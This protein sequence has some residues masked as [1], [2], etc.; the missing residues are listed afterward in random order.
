[1]GDS[2]ML[3][4]RFNPRSQLHTGSGMSVPH[5]RDQHMLREIG[6]DVFQAFKACQVKSLKISVTQQSA[7]DRLNTAHYLKSI[8]PSRNADY[9][10]IAK[11][12]A[13]VCHTGGFSVHLNLWCTQVIRLVKSTTQLGLISSEDLLSRHGVP[14]VLQNVSST[15]AFLGC[16]CTKNWVARTCT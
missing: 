15:E 10:Q 11:S 14:R 3:S 8:A 5:D 4:D 9:H 13:V 2:S 12:I 16:P 1:M 7:G 6:I